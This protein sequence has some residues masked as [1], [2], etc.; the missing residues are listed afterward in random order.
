MSQ[1]IWVILRGVWA[2]WG[3]WGCIGGPSPCGLQSGQSQSTIL[4]HPQHAIFF[5][6][7]LLRHQNISLSERNYNWQFLLITLYI[8]SYIFQGWH[9]GRNCVSTE[10]F[11]RCAWL[12]NKS[13][14]WIPTA[15]CWRKWATGKNE[16]K[17]CINPPLLASNQ[18]SQTRIYW[19]NISWLNLVLAV[20][21]STNIE[22]AM[23]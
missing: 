18:S 12:W 11:T 7:T 9:L 13:Y 21:R 16:T 14:L 10:A 15:T 4:A 8:N 23:L 5:H 3:V 22:F 17:P 19:L 2:A 6:L 20:K 1:I